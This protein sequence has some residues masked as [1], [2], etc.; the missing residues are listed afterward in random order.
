MDPIERGRLTE[1]RGFKALS[2]LKQ[3]HPRFILR[4]RRTSSAVDGRGIDAVVVIN[5]PEG[6]KKPYMS[7]PMEFKSSWW[8]VSK[9]KVAHSDL[10]KAGVLIFRV[11]KSE[12]KAQRLMYRAL[13]RVQLNSD[14]GMLYHSMFQRLFKG[15][16]RN[17]WRNIALIKA[18]RAQE[19]RSS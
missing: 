9:W 11:P 14:D 13:H 18:R 19:R 4:V 1:E 6:T 7:V 10:H 17:L 16:S 2:V 3:K 5:L 15:G 12:H 8:G